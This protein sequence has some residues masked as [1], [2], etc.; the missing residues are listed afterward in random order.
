M[1]E[2]TVSRP[3]RPKQ[4]LPRVVVRIVVSHGNAEIL[5]PLLLAKGRAIYERL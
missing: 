1:L 3:K 2:P 4:L 5:T